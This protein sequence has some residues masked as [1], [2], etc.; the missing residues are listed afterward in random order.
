MTRRHMY[1]VITQRITY[2][3]TFIALIVV[4]LTVVERCDTPAAPIPLQIKEPSPAGNYPVATALGYTWIA[5]E[6]GPLKARLAQYGA[7]CPS[8]VPASTPGGGWARSITPPEPS[9][10][11][12]LRNLRT[13]ALVAREMGVSPQ[14][15]RIL[16]HW[17]HRESGGFQ[18]LLHL[19]RGDVRAA[20]S[21]KAR[22]R[23]AAMGREFTSE[24]TYGRGWYGMQPSY[25]MARWPVDAP[26]DVLCDPVAS[27]MTAIWAARDHQRECTRGGWSPSLLV[28]TRRFASGHC[29]PREKDDATTAYWLRHGV[30]VYHRAK[31]GTKWPQADHVRALT[32]MREKVRAAGLDADSVSE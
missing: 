27:T 21:T 24:W 5:P 10:A 15:T 22:A 6:R 29:R 23:V 14:T 18:Y 11:Q 32:Y 16:Q 20:S 19:M 30:N 4:C 7:R 9:R 31:W 12:V 25:Y 8:P 1:A 17:G 2:L 26:L 28:S 13:I 3:L